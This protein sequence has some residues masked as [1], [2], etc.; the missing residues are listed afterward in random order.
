MR[1]RVIRLTA[2]AILLFALSTGAVSAQTVSI[3]DY[4]GKYTL[5]SPPPDMRPL[6][7]RIPE[8]FRFGSSILAPRDWGVT[9]LTYYPSFTSPLD[10]ANAKYGGS[11]AGSCNGRILIYVENREHG[12]AAWPNIADFIAHNTTKLLLTPP[13]PANVTV[14][15]IEPVAGYD[16]GFERTTYRGPHIIGRVERFYF[17]KTADKSSY[18]LTAECDGMCTLHFSLRC[19]PRGFIS[20]FPLDSGRLPLSKDIEQKT[21]RCIS[22][23]V[24]DSRCKVASEAATPGDE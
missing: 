17:H 3:Y 2:A 5:A 4:V 7:L 21:D 11:C 24:E 6:V 14:R 22:A 23:M 20:V 15:T 18:D 10:P 12:L 8:G 13:Y 1:R 9:I 19:D 16:E